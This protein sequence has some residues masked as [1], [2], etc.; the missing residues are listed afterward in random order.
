MYKLIWLSEDDKQ[1]IINFEGIPYNIIEVNALV[2]I[3]KYHP[4]REECGCSMVE[5]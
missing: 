5:Y 1:I 2:L 3:E 4:Y